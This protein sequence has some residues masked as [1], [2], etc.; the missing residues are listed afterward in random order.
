MAAPTLRSIT[1]GEL[2]DGDSL[3]SL[4]CKVISI[5]G[6]RPFKVQPGRLF[7]FT[8]SDKTGLYTNTRFRLDCLFSP[9]KQT[10][11]RH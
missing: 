1:I 4:N 2:N 8:V 10:N 9:L 3:F 6:M 5:A 7:A 11:P